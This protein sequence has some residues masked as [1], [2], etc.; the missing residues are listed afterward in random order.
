MSG[1]GK[2]LRGRM[3][4]SVAVSNVDPRE[5]KRLEVEVIEMESEVRGLRQRQA[6]LE[7][8]IDELQPALRQMQI[9]LEK[10]TRELQSLQQQQPNL[11]RQIKEQ[12]AR[13]KSTKADAAQ[14]KKLTAIVEQKKEEYEE[15]AETAG[16]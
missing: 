8:R 16:E 14:V 9:D 4:Q 15:A 6:T 1:G 3:G 12:E 13:S 11:K 10:H 2:R 7:N 5:L